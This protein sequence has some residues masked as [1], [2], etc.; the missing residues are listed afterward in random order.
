MILG[1]QAS[2]G[3]KQTHKPKHLGVGLLFKA[4]PTTPTQRLEGFTSQR[5]NETIAQ[6]RAAD[7]P[8]HHL[9]DSYTRVH[10][11]SASK[12]KRQASE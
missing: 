1:F 2:Y 7:N 4:G 9:L 12:L 8:V 6:G 10:T 3:A 11:S 5:A